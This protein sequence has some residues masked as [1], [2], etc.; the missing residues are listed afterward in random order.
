MIISEISQ[1]PHVIDPANECHTICQPNKNPRR[2]TSEWFAENINRQSNFFQ[3]AKRVRESFTIVRRKKLF[4]LSS[5]I[6]PT[7]KILLFHR[8]RRRGQGKESKGQAVQKKLKQK[9]IRLGL[10]KWVNDDEI[11]KVKQ[12]NEARVNSRNC[13][14]I[15][16]W[17]VTSLT[18]DTN[19]TKIFRLR[20]RKEK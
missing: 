12:I 6:K 16:R 18:F 17:N 14:L 20:K 2:E 5:A 9:K 13:Q 19:N 15:C 7:T 4:C 3:R 10:W 8:S 1:T 11:T